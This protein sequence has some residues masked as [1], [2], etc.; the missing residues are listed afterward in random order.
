MRAAAP[1]GPNSVLGLDPLKAA[2]KEMA[3]F[4]N[5]RID[6]CDRQHGNDGEYDD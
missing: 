2:R 5:N 3:S 1:H 4:M 6:D